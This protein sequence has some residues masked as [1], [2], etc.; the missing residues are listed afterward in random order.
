MLCDYIVSLFF[1][2]FDNIWVHGLIAIQIW[3][4]D[5]AFKNN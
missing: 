2:P 4:V 1:L 3:E 5:R